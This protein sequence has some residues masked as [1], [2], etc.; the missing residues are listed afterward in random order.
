MSPPEAAALAA[1][2]AAFSELV[3]YAGAGLAEPAT[4]A[5]IWSDTSGVRFQ[6]AGNTVRQV[7]CEVR[8]S[9]LPHKPAKADRITRDGVVWRPNEVTP[10]DDIGKWDIVLERVGAAS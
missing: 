10:R 7:S 3:L 4:I 8:K 9:D 5:V 1:N 2:D 6:G